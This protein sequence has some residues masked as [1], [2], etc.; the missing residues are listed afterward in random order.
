MPERDQT[1]I[2]ERI[3]VPEV[4]L[5]D[6]QGEQA[7]VMKIDDA[8]K[9]AQDRDLDLVEVAPEAKPPVCRVLDYS[10]YKYEQAQKVKAAKKGQQQITIREIKFRPKIAEHD[11]AT[12]RGHVMRFLMHKDKV[13]VTIMFRGREVTHPEQGRMILE[14]LSLELAPIGQIDQR[15]NLD[16]RNMT[17]ILAPTKEVLGGEITEFVP[18]DLTNEEVQER[19]R[20]GSTRRQP[21]P[22]AAAPRKGFFGRIGEFFSGLRSRF[23]NWRLRNSTSAEGSEI[24]TSAIDEIKRTEGGRHTFAEEDV[25]GR[26]AR[27]GV[28]G[29]ETGK[30]RTKRSRFRNTPMKRDANQADAKRFWDLDFQLNNLGRRP[31]EP[32]IQ[33][34]RYTPV[35]GMPRKSE[36]GR[37]MTDFASKGRGGF[38]EFSG[39]PWRAKFI[40]QRAT[41]E[42]LEAARMGAVFSG[43][44]P[45]STPKSR[46][47]LARKYG[48]KDRSQV[49]PEAR[50]EGMEEDA[51]R[52]DDLAS[53]EFD[54][55]S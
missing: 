37:A 13:K 25:Q 39:L 23:R 14:R 18:E 31:D 5:I 47:E 48:P 28:R 16:G 17:M 12:K 50:S 49:I 15:P 33:S 40:Q 20:P 11:Y 54:E 32:V 24:L 6:D 9:F 27:Q 3:R 55:D 42:A 8:L 35:E 53:M 41:K 43:L 29:E 21:E 4:R 52:D 51:P 44:T 45:F 22:A 26:L 10:K 19:I 30:F 34:K 46:A 1:R 7:G 2:N 38:S 36:A